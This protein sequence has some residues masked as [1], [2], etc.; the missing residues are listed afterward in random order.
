MTLERLTGGS[1]S[2]AGIDGRL[3][4]PPEVAP[5]SVMSIMDEVPI[6]LSPFI[7]VNRTA[8]YA[9][10]Q[11]SQQRQDHAT[12]IGFVADAVAA[13]V[14]ELLLTRRALVDLALVWE[15]RRRLR[16]GSAAMRALSLLIDY[17]VV[18]VRRL[19][20]RLG[21]SFGQ[22]SSAIGQL[23]DAGILNERTGYSRNRLFAA[24]EALALINRPFG[25]EPV[26][27]F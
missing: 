5:R 12:M 16:A 17:P 14:Q 26:M 18:T 4:P 24:T 19:A 3:G 1:A 25:E 21:V 22:A 27:A 8:Y 15:T 6:Y 7:K 11:A 20:E 23:I 9:A 13:T 10:L 2:A